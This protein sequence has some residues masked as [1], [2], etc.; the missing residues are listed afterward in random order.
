MRGWNWQMVAGVLVMVAAVAM[1]PGATVNGRSFI[2]DAVL[3][4]GAALFWF[5]RRVRA[6]KDRP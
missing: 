2:A 3:V 5:G 6:E 4:G 1:T